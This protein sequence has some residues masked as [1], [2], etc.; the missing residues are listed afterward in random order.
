MSNYNFVVCPSYHGAT[1]LSCFLGNHSQVSSMGDT[2]PEK[3]FLE[4]GA[5]TCSCG[6]TIDACVFWKT[7]IEE[8]NPQL[9]YRDNNILPQYPVILD[10]EKYNRVLAKC[11]GLVSLNVSHSI[12]K[13]FAAQCSEFI[14]QYSNFYSLVCSQHKTTHFID[15]KKNLIKISVF[16]GMESLNSRVKVIHLMRDPRAVFYSHYKR[17]NPLTVENFCKY[18]VAFHKRSQKLGRQLGAGSYY[19]L[20]YEKFCQFPNE[21]LTLLQEF[22]GVPREELIQINSNYGS[23]HMIGSTMLQKFNGIVKLD[24][25]WEKSLPEALQQKV[26]RLTEPLFSK[27][28]YQSKL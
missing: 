5:A 3:Q 9:V 22:L 21:I 28:G 12:W 13:I 2:L 7:I 4:E 17:N 23:K 27:M 10:N 15:G 8:V 11:L 18:W 25:K 26:V 19:P 6:E 20:R 14:E 24:T 16:L 1:L